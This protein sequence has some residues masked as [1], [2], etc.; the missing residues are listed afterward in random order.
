MRE[1]EA[2]TGDGGVDPL[3]FY[4]KKLALYVVQPRV[5]FEEGIKFLKS[6]QS[7]TLKTKGQTL[8]VSSDFNFM[9]NSLTPLKKIIS[10]EIKF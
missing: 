5:L 6:F 7:K 9:P 10:S 3:S 4:L 2:Q 1:M 8:N